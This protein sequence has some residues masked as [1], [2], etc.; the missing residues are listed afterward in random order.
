MVIP[1]R[2]TLLE[3]AILTALE[4][5]PNES[6]SLNYMPGSVLR[7]A[8]I[9]RYMSGKRP[10]ELDAADKSVRDLFFNGS[11]RYLNAYPLGYAGK[12]SLPAPLSWHQDKTAVSHEEDDSPAPVYDFAI[13]NILGDIE[14]PIR[15]KK[16]FYTR[17][18]DYVRFVRPDYQLS[19]H[20][21]RNRRYGRAMRLSPGFIGP[22]DEAYGAVYRYT[23]LV[24]RQ[25]FK[26]AIICDNDRDAETL[27]PLLEGEVFLGGS[28][29]AGYGRAEIC[30]E[31]D[32]QT[33][34]NWREAWVELKYEV[35]GNLIITFLSDSLLRNR[36]GQYTAS[37]EAL[38]E[39][40]Q[41]KLKIR[42]DQPERSFIRTR[43][44]G[45]FNRKWGLPLPQALAVRMG[46]V[47]VYHLDDGSSLDKS[48]LAS[49]EAQG[50][51]ERRAEGFGRL[52][53]N[54]HEEKKLTVKTKKPDPKK[55]PDINDEESKAVA[56]RIVTRIFQQRLESKL[57]ASAKTASGILANNEDKKKDLPRNAQ[58]SR[59]RSVILNELMKKN[60]EID[61]RHVKKYLSDI[62]SRKSASEQF[63]NARVGN[64]SLLD[65]LKKT[66]DD[67]NLE[68]LLGFNMRK[69]PGIGGVK[70]RFDEPLR[71]RYLLRYID[72][73]LA[74]AV[75]GKN[76]GG[77]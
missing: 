12:R 27:L 39:I 61:I 18:E 31:N 77:S 64:R 55:V 22:E 66:L 38:T 68:D 59:F 67:H 2:I 11:T 49:L 71:K 46:S 40:F 10:K 73:I 72:D 17:G 44:V 16:P 25:S 21:A 24:A 45:G 52:A 30:V 34:E 74:S 50:I 69:M 3:P 53:F 5:D 75:K 14:Q 35:S 48:L 56:E 41:D 37:I 26:A 32:E 60:E 76:R 13:N 58:I 6:V 63:K 9:G 36:W 23:A 7:G 65:W 47:L 70:P 28:R 62:E 19:V 43:V 42:L 20:T 4:G 8:V 29:T 57:I 1:Y 15:V 54:C 51:G 33:F